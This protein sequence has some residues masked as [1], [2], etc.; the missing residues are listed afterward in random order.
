MDKWIVARLNQVVERVGAYLNISDFM[1]ASQECAGLLDDLSNWYVRCNRRRFWKSE[2]DADKNTAYATLYHV[3]VKFTKTL[4]PFIPF[5]TEAIYQNVVRSVRS[6]AYESIQGTRG[7][8]ERHYGIPASDVAT[9]T[10][11]SLK[12]TNTR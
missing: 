2:H 8:S 12:K 7:D 11:N 9:E 3:L 4:A 1:S 6:G 5:I 10:M